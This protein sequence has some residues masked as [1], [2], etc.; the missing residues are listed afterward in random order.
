MLVTHTNESLQAGRRPLVAVDVR[1]GLRY[2]RRGVGEY[3]FRLVEE[4]SRQPLPFDLLLLGD[5]SA[6]PSVVRE[7]S[8]A[9]PVQLLKVEPFARWEQWAFPRAVSSRGA[10]LIHGTANIAPLA[11]MGP[12]VLTVHDVIEWHRGRDFGGRIPPRHHL[13]RIYRMNALKY[14]ARRADL[15]L[16]VSDHASGDLGMTLKVPQHR[17]RVTP[18][19]PK[20]EAAPPRWPKDP[21]FVTLGA[22]DPRKNL[23]G[24]LRAWA[25]TNLAGVRLI[26]VGVERPAIPAVRARIEALGL[27]ERVDLS[28]MVDDGELR[29]LMA[30][31]EGLIYLS[32]YEGFGLPLLEAMAV[33]CPVIASNRASLPEVG[34]D[35]ALFVDPNRIEDV[36]GFIARLATD[37]ALRRDLVAKGYKRVE[38]FSWKATAEATVA[39]YR[40]ILERRGYL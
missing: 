31:A 30:R 35:A 4:W 29:D 40:E 5:G 36:A 10:A 19:A 8:S 11:W 1:Y 23:D 24:A 33:G 38:A 15:V 39:A 3:V 26:V 17:V 13:S 21:F 12:L 28:E 9:F 22:L 37:E 34:G 27:R 7:V 25:K 20:W 32:H 6:D 16:T 2:P 18:L 14:L